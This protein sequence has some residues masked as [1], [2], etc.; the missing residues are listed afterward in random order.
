M[1]DTQK[2]QA[3]ELMA[4]MATACKDYDQLVV[5]TTLEAAMTAE[6]HRQDSLVGQ[7]FEAMMS[8]FRQ[9]A[10]V[11]IGVSILMKAVKKAKMEQDVDGTPKTAA[12]PTCDMTAEDYKTA[13]FTCHDPFHKTAVATVDND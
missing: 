10:S 6:I 11:L 9:E 4:K 2:E 12:C 13:P 3:L 5:M 7:L 8:E 1:T